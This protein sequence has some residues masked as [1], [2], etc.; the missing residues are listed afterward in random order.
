MLFQQQP[1]PM[2]DGGFGGHYQTADYDSRNRSGSMSNRRGGDGGGRRQHSRFDSGPGE[3]RGDFDGRGGG[4]SRFDEPPPRV[5]GHRGGGRDFRGPVGPPEPPKRERGT[6]E[7][8]EL[9]SYFKRFSY[10]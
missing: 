1:P 7:L 10:D 3:R 6:G 9:E 2:L 5:G 4:R 8:T